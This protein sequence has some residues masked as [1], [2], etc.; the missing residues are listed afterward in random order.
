MDEGE[1]NHPFSRS[2]ENVVD[3]NGCLVG[4]SGHDLHNDIL[5]FINCVTC[6]S[7]TLNASSLVMSYSWFILSS[8]SLHL[9]FTTFKLLS[10]SFL[11]IIT[12]YKVK[13]TP[14]IIKGT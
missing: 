7:V 3:Q 12:L 6:V 9:D 8:L 13:H 1:D 11:Y 2:L 10:P 4:L 14:I 5:A